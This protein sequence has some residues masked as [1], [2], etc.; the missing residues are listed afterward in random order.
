MKDTTPATMY[1]IKEIYDS[2]IKGIEVRDEM[3]AICE[4]EITL[5]KEMIL[6]L[7][8]RVEELENK[9]NYI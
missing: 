1:D 6:S 9:A 2:M 5:Y 3:F 8:R 4:K 7:E